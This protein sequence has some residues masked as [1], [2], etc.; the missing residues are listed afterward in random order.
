[1]IAL[2]LLIALKTQPASISTPVDRAWSILDDGIKNKDAAKRAKAI[3]AL[4]L[5]RNSRQA[6]GFAE[7]AL[8][9]ENQEVRVEAA[10]AL[11]RLGVSSASA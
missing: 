10:T 7:N 2:L 4:G 8:E 11:G 3:H 1:M 9:D 6:E 5:L